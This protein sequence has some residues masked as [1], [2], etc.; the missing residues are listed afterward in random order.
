MKRVLHLMIAVAVV[1][2]AS[3]ATVAAQS[4]RFGV[5]GGL[6]SPLSD[7]KDADKTG[8]HALASAEFGIPLSPVGIRVDG[9]YGQT[10]HQAPLDNDGNTKLM[11]ALASLVWKIPVSAPLVKPYVLAGGGFYNVKITIPSQTVDTSESKFAYAFGAGLNV[12]VGPLHAF[13]EGRY[14]SIQTSGTSTK[15]IPVTVGLQFG[16]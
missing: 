15:F 3:A 7:Y 8:W 16:M 11:G 13:V 9:L 14:V 2:V 5:G 6:I 10:K 12:G 1:S 4:V